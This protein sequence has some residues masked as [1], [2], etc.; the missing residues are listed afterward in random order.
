MI[1]HYLARQKQRSITIKILSSTYN[2]LQL[3]HHFLSEERKLLGRAKFAGFLNNSKFSTFTVPIMQFDFPTNCCKN[4]VF[5]FL[6]GVII[7]P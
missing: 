6:L 4:I 1:A 5:N 3:K 7:V 2:K